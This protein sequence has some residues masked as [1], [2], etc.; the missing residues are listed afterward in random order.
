MVRSPSCNS[1]DDKRVVPEGPAVGGMSLL[2]V[3][4]EEVGQ[5]CVLLHQTVEVTQ[6]GHERRSGAAPKVQHLT[7]RGGGA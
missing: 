2:D 3:D 7:K 4:D 1:L 6:L 5:V